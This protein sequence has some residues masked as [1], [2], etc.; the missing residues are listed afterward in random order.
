MAQVIT[1]LRIRVLTKALK[2]LE[3]NSPGRK[4][5]RRSLESLCSGKTSPTL[6][7]LKQ[8]N[9]LGSIFLAGNHQVLATVL[10]LNAMR[11]FILPE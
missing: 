11:N 9:G 7:L 5:E 6:P 1:R 2:I 3:T 10:M 4:Y 8:R